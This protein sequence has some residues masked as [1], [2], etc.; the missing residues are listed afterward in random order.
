MNILR[1]KSI[2]HFL[3][4]TLMFLYGFPVF[5]ASFSTNFEFSDNTGSFTLAQESDTVIF[6][7]GVAKSVGNFSLYRSGSNAWMIDAGL[8]FALTLLIALL[9]FGIGFFVFVFTY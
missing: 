2:S 9:T 5:S 3:I 4:F 1:L 7:N 8:I 6:T